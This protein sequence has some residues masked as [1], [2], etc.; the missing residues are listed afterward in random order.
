ML[1]ITALSLPC[2]WGQAAA[3]TLPVQQLNKQAVRFQMEGPRSLDP[4]W[5]GQAWK[6][7]LSHSGGIWGTRATLRRRNS[8]K[9]LTSRSAL[10]HTSHS[11]LLVSAAGWTAWTNNSNTTLIIRW[12][13]MLWEK[14][15]LVLHVLLIC[16]VIFELGKWLYS[17]RCAVPRGTKRV[18]FSQ[19]NAQYGLLYT[20]ARDKI[21]PSPHVV[22]LSYL[23]LCAL[24]IMLWKRCPRTEGQ[25][26]EDIKA[27]QAETR[28]INK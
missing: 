19:S 24:C 27:K 26:R 6:P 7:L 1:L 14:W 3:S 11:L 20:Y 2:F 10:L 16:A 22:T 9:Q 13:I 28:E 17:P 21:I 12:S 15:R 8:S 4:H 5:S 23:V 18:V 25:S